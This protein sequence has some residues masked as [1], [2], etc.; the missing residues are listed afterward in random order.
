MTAHVGR[1]QS[2]TLTELDMEIGVNS[3]FDR[4]SH[5]KKLRDERGYDK[6]NMKT[7][8]EMLWHQLD[9]PIPIYII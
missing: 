2:R 6:D 5:E 9:D 3:K 4:A 7:C 1:A 8:I